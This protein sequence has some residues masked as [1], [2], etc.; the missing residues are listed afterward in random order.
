MTGYLR[1]SVTHYPINGGIITNTS[2]S[3]SVISNENGFFRISTAPN[4]LIYIYARSYQN[5]TLRYST[6]FADT[7]DFFLSPTGSLLPNVIVQSRYTKYQLDSIERKINFEENIGN[8]VAVVSRPQSGAFGVGINLDRAFKKRDAE[9]NKYEKAY[10]NGEKAAYVQYRFSPHLVALYTQLKGEALRA[11]MN[12]YTPS[13]DWLRQHTTND[14]V[15]I[16]I[17]DKLKLFKATQP[18]TGQPVK[19]F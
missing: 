11:F 2:R 14:E 6:L 15:L 19:A 1:D 12:R 9:K 10:Y 4:D 5:D 3:A 8:K 7:I 18:N 16:Y 13:Y 17:N